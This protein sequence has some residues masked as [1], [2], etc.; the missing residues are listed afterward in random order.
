[1]KSNTSFIIMSIFTS[2]IMGYSIYYFLVINPEKIKQEDLR[3]VKCFCEQR[4][5]T[6]NLVKWTWTPD[7]AWATCD[8]SDNTYESTGIGYWPLCN[9]SKPKPVIWEGT[10]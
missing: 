3:Q 5:H 1:M 4:Y 2:I 7:G 6:G 10:Q 8:Y 9:D